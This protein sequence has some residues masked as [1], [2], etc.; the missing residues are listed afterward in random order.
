MCDLHEPYDTRNMLVLWTMV[1][2]YSGETN[3]RLNDNQNST[4]IAAT[5]AATQTQQQSA[6]RAEN[7]CSSSSVKYSKPNREESRIA[8]QPPSS[9]G[10]S[11]YEAPHPSRSLLLRHHPHVCNTYRAFIWKR[12]TDSQ[13]RVPHFPSEDAKL[14]ATNLNVRRG[15]NCPNSLEVLQQLPG[16]R[17][18]VQTHLVSCLPNASSEATRRIISSFGEDPMVDFTHCI[19]REENTEAASS[20][21]IRSQESGSRTIV[22]YNGLKEM[23]AAEFEK[24]VQR[25]RADQET[26][27]HFEV[28][29]HEALI[30]MPLH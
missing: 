9:R 14:R 22:N 28:R 11:R 4:K 1:V 24:I 27:W 23:T 17:K 7:C 19:Y 2:V 13:F 30:M 3:H 6:Y 25:F 15:G 20:Y 8:E 5:T 10:S 18:D 16:S 26:W 29:V 21:I 12:L